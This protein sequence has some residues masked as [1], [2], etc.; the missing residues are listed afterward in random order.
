MIARC[1]GA[2][3]HVEVRGAGVPLLLVHGFPHDHTLWRPQLDALG[4]TARVVAPDLRGF[5]RSDGVGTP[6][7]ASVTAG[8]PGGASMD[9][10]ADDLACVLDAVGERRAVVVG[11]SMGGYVAFALWRRHR[12]RVRALVLADTRAGADTDDARAKRRE[13]IGVARQQ[14]AGA[15]AERMLDGMVGKST[16]ARRPEVVTAVRA[17]LAAQPVASIVDALQAMH[18]R[19]DSTPDLATIDVP[20]LVVVGDEDVLTPVAEARRLHE[21]IAG[22]RLEVL[23]GAGHV[24]NLERPAAFTHVLRELLAALP[25]EDG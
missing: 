8:A 17:L 3:L 7:S 15:V 19:P 21:A 4:D 14:G 6:G 9:R 10:Y 18:D 11:L 22:S 24:S 23:A 1:A 13:L 20:T 5:G 25:P 16:R 12:A 2:A